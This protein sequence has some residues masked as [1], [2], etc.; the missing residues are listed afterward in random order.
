MRRHLQHPLP[1]PDGL[2]VISPVCG[3]VVPDVRVFGIELPSALVL[4]LRLVGT[5]QEFE[6]VSVAHVQVSIVRVP[7]DLRL[8]ALKTFQRV[9]TAPAGRKLYV[10]HGAGLHAEIAAV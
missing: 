7:G 2:G 9:H 8:I 3:Q 10:L 1:Q 5:P 4:G 6:R